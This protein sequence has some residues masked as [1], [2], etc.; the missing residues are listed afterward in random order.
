MTQNASGSPRPS[1]PSQGDTRHRLLNGTLQS[2]R[3]VGV[4]GTT[5]RA[6]AA[7][8]GV[9]L[10]GITYH[11]GAK[12]DLVAAALVQVIRDWLEPALTILR[13]EADPVTRMVST[14]QALQVIFE[15][16]SDDLPVIVEAIARAPRDPAVREGVSS[17]FA[18]LGTLLVGQMRAMQQ[19]G[20][21]PD[22]I[23]PPA[24]A[25]LLLAVGE[26]VA[27]HAVV[28][29]GTVNAQALAAQM[30]Q[31]LLSARADPS[32]STGSAPIA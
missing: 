19:L 17:I 4:A 13:S 8:S 26:G 14:I 11:F 22:W 15:S 32:S 23:D 7:A 21:L 31:L 18:E 6:I 20:F 9:N 25:T 5:S 2:L 1:P 27:L 29:P 28:D 16:S 24:M 3:E 12:D 10:G 30:I